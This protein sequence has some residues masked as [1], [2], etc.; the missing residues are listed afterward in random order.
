[1]EIDQIY[2]GHIVR[3]NHEKLFGFIEAENG[4]LYFFHSATE[5][6]QQKKLKQEGLLPSVHTYKSGDYVSFKLRSIQKEDFKYEAYDVKFLANERRNLL[7]NEYHKNGILQGYIKI[8]DSGKLFI[9]DINTYVY[10]PIFISDWE[11]NKDEVYIK[12]EN[13]LVSFRLNQTVKIDKLHAVLQDAKFIDEYYELMSHFD[14]QT[15]LQAIITGKNKH[16]YFALLCNGKIEGFIAM[17]NIFNGAIIKE[18]NFSKLRKGD[19]ANV[20]IKSRLQPT[21]LRVSLIFD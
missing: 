18:D 6:N 9:K 8:F 13:K 21:S 5:Q 1:M 20:R 12:R 19:T 7:I 2:S 3:L 4:E 11:F 15:T 17:K 10:L 16:G 14:N